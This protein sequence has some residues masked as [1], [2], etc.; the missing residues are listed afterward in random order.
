MCALT[1]LAASGCG[2]YSDVVD[3]NPDNATYPLRIQPSFGIRGTTIDGVLIT[4]EGLK[5]GI[6]GTDVFCYSTGMSF[7]PQDIWAQKSE[8]LDDCT[9]IK[10][11]LTIPADA[12]PDG[13]RTLTLDFTHS[14]EGQLSASADFYV[15]TGSPDAD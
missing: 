7:S 2:A 11:R 9:G 14:I 3:D 8:T 10:A 15:G 13:L 5:P 4:F 1:M 12:G 6:R